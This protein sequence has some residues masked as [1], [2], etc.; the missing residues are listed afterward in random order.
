MPKT[1]KCVVARSKL[2]PHENFFLFEGPQIS[3]SFCF[4]ALK[5]RKLART[6][7]FQVKGTK[8]VTGRKNC[9]FTVC[10]R[11]IAQL[12]LG[13]EVWDFMVERPSLVIADRQ[14]GLFALL[15]TVSLVIILFCVCASQLGKTLRNA[16]PL[17][18]FSRFEQECLI[19]SRDNY[20][21]VFFLF[22]S[23]PLHPV[24]YT[25]KSKGV[26][27]VDNHCWRL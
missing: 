12:W 6:N 17:V 20:V 19:R 14:V 15:R 7:Q 27:D 22:S 10:N 21:F 1:T 9:D 16:L 5:V 26:I 4:E 13:D 2:M 11:S 3:T 25:I 24:L 18:F 23:P 8:M